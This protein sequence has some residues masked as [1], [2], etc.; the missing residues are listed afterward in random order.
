MKKILYIVLY[1]CGWLGAQTSIGI[2][3]PQ[4][5]INITGYR[6]PQWSYSTL[7]LDLSGMV[8][9]QDQDFKSG[10]QKSTTSTNAHG[11]AAGSY[12][13][14]V[15]SEAQTFHLQTTLK[16]AL[17]SGSTTRTYKTYDDNKYSNRKNNSSFY[18]DA[19]WL[20]Y[21]AA[22][23]FVLAG[24]NSS[25]K[26]NSVAAEEKLVDVSSLNN[27]QKEFSSAVDVH[28]G[29]GIG[30][31]RN[32]TPVV[33]ALRIRERLNALDYDITLD[34]EDIQNMAQQLAKISGY[35]GVYDR[36]DKYFWQDFSNSIGV[37]ELAPY[38]QYYIQDALH[39]NI[40]QRYNGWM[41]AF[42]LF[43]TDNR[44]ELNEDYLSI[45]SNPGDLEDVVRET[46]S[47]R[48][49]DFRQWGP[50]ITSRWVKNITLR[51]Q[52]GATA[53]LAWSMLLKDKSY[54]Y[55]KSDDDLVIEQ[56]NCGEEPQTLSVSGGLDYLWALH[57][58]LLW[59]TNV[60]VYWLDYTYN[61]D[62]FEPYKRPGHINADDDGFSLNYALDSQFQ[63]YIENNFVL[64]ANFQVAR[65]SD[66]T[67]FFICDGRDTPVAYWSDKEGRW[68]WSYS[69]GLTYFLDR[70]MF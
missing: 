12:Y 66:K 14:F 46:N 43:Y 69:I 38:E 29:Y 56:W 27:E 64:T 50:Y 31:L 24:L 40:G 19:E 2:Q 20:R 68:T 25:F 26:Y 16:S 21:V 65:S 33:R 35:N 17:M 18:L 6:L 60:N 9:G 49:K 1:A 11:I 23:S 55:S 28:I 5:T 45:R 70:K 53:H 52:L 48:I 58:R 10:N 39:E 4:N 15:E 7:A 8:N 41:T 62:G 51:H 59:T 63:Y 57:D 22:H 13:H 32:V 44:T 47:E 61:V 36:S 37:A 34:D 3:N 42:G 67:T 30:R 54:Y